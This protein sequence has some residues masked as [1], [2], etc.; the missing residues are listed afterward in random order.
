MK[1]D[2]KAKITES[3]LAALESGGFS[4]WVKPWRSVGRPR[5]LSTGNDAR[6]INRWTLSAATLKHGYGSQYWGTLRAI[7]QRGG[8]VKAGE[9]GT[10]VVFFK[11]FPQRE[12]NEQGE[13]VERVRLVGSVYT[14]FNL[15]QTTLAPIVADTETPREIPNAESVAREYLT[16]E[17]IPLT[18]H[19]DAAFYSPALDE[20]T[21][22]ARERFATTE[23]IYST[24]YH[25]I[26]HSTGHAQRL[27]R[28]GVTQR[29]RF[30]SEPY[31]VEELT[32]EFGTLLLCAHVGIETET[33]N[34]VAYLANW[35]AAIRADS[36]MVIQAASQAEKAVDFALGNNETNN[37][38]NN[39]GAN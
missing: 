25:E 1:H 17:K 10:P 15:E 12:T 8:R 4:A 39:D 3:I 18:E 37:E 21:I 31:G 9:H 13:T 36:G 29:A 32:A 14:E 28:P 26:V 35:K 27:A 30:G 23:A 7:N 20:I 34:G 16:R 6:G 2:V 19:G 5:Y 11:A 38:T 22:P 24:L 33:G